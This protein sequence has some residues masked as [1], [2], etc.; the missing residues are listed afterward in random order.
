MT[1]TFPRPFPVVPRLFSDCNFDVMRYQAKNDLRGSVTQV[2][3]VA[4]ARWSGEWTTTP[5][6]RSAAQIWKAWKNS[7]RGGLNQ[8]LGYDAERPFPKTYP[9]G[10][11][12]LV[13][14][15]GSTPFTGT[16]LD[17]T[18]LTTT[19]IAL[20]LLP[21]SFVF[22]VGDLIGLTEGAYVGLYEI[23]EDVTANGSGVATITVEPFVATNV[24]TAAA[25]GNLI[26]P[27]AIMILDHE[28]WSAP[29]NIDQQP[30]TFKAVQKLV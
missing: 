27:P 2:I 29:R 17:V 6:D 15:G 13:Q 21:A 1:I 11:A 26:K 9:T 18:A 25:V 12:G 7:L 30:I 22:K 14:A 8:F 3:D 23:Q 19:T 4:D 5:C 28:S 10:F 24:F 16:A 20:A